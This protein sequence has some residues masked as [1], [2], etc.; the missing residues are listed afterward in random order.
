MSFI[1]ALPGLPSQVKSGIAI[2][3]ILG[4]RRTAGLAMPLATGK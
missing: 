4:S 2:E 3:I 1:C